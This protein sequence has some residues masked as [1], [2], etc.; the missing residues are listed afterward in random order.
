MLTT[1]AS[2]LLRRNANLGGRLHTVLG[3]VHH[4]DLRSFHRGETSRALGAA[5]LRLFVERELLIAA[6][7]LDGERFGRRID[8]DQLT[9]GGCRLL[10]RRSRWSSL[11]RAGSQREPNERDECGSG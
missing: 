9:R 5:D 3:R 1:R 11:P 8:L 7:G 10:S 4:G 6:I 2:L